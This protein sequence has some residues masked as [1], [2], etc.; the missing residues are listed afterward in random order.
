MK[1]PNW[2]PGYH[3]FLSHFEDATG[4]GDVL[5]TSFNLHDSPLVCS[6][7]DAIEMFENSGLQYLALGAFC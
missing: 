6:P 1:K 5:N 2:H 7:K 3:V 4:I